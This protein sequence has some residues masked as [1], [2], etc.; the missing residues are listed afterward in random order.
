MRFLRHV[1]IIKYT[2]NLQFSLIK[3]AAKESL[4][5]DEFQQM[6]QNYGINIQEKDLEALYE[7][8]DD[9]KD[10]KGLIDLHS[11]LLYKINLTLSLKYNRETQP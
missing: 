11:F 2:C 7:I 8:V 10:S 9:D 3:H 6:F 4:D 1:G 5:M